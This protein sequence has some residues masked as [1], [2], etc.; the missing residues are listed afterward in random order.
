M[1]TI[2]KITSLLILSILFFPSCG[3]EDGGSN[4]T[5]G[6]ERPAD[7][8][9]FRS[10]LDI[11]PRM[12]T[13]AL[14]DNLWAAYST[15]NGSLYKAWKG[16]V[17]F[18]GAVYTTAHGP[19]PTSVGDA[20]ILGNSET[21]PWLIIENGQ[22]I[23]PTFQY[24]GHRFSN[25][26]AEMMYELSWN[27]KKAIVSEQPEYLDNGKGKAGFERTFTTSNV[28][29]GSQVALMANTSSVVSNSMVKTNGDFQ[30]INES[31]REYKKLSGVDLEGKLIL[32]SN[33]KTHFTSTFMARPLIPDPNKKNEEEE[34]ESPLGQRLIAKSDCKSCHNTFR[35]TIG[36]A[37]NDIAKKYSNT[38]Q[39]VAL[40]SAKIKNGGYGVW[41]SQ[42]MSAHPNESM[43]EIN[44]MVKYIMTLDAEEEAQM[45]A[46]SKES[47]PE[48]LDY[49]YGQKDIVENELLPG[50]IGTVYKDGT[51]LEKLADIKTDSKPIFVG[52]I[53][54]VHA[55]AGDLETLDH[56]FGIILEGYLNIPADANYTFRLLSDDGSRL[57]INGQVVI[58]NDGLHGASP[59]DG[60]IALAKGY[61]KLKVEYF[62]HGGGKMFSLEWR[63]GNEFQRVPTTA[64]LHNKNEE[65]QNFNVSGLSSDTKIPGDGS[66]LIGVHPSYDLTQARPG[67]FTP[68]VGGMDFLDDG[69]L[70][71]CTWDPNGSVYIVEG[72]QGGDPNK[73][74]Y[75][76]IGAGLAEPLGLKVVDNE[77]YILQ[78]QELTKLVDTDGDDMI[79]EYQT[80]C[81][82]WNVSANFHEFAFGLVY[83]EG[84][85]Y[86]TLAT[87]INPGGASTQP[88]I[89]DRGR[90]V[91]ISKADGSM[92]LI[93]SGL[94]TPNGIGLGV[95]NE[96]FV[97][98][99]QGDWLPASKIVHIK[100]GGWYG[101]RS[102]DFE[103]TEGMKENL[104]VVWLPQDEIGNSPSTPMYINDGIYTGQMIHG[105][106]TNGGVKRVFV[107]KI[108]GEYQ[109]CLFRFTQGLEA[110]VNRIIW[111]PDGA[112]YAG[113]VGSTGNWVHD[114]KLWYGLQRLKNNGKSTFEM[115]AV[116]A[117][118][119]GVE[120]EFTEPL[121]SGD[122]WNKSDYGVRQWFYKPTKEYGGPK[123]DEKALNIRSVNVSDDRKKVF[124]ELDGM[125]SNHMVYIKINT[126]FSSALGHEIWSTEAWYTMNQIPTGE[127]GFKTSAPPAT[128]VN[129][130][131]AFEKAA[132]WKSLF[133]GKS[134]AGWRNF[135]KQTV[136]SGWIVKD[137]AI[138]LNSKKGADGNWEAKDGGD[139]ITEGQYENYELSLEWKIGACGNSGVIF[140]VVE[141]A[142]YE[143]VWQT[144]P[145]M[146]VLDNTCHPDAKIRTHRAGDLYDMIECKYVTVKPAGQWNHARLVINKGKTEHW[147]NGRKVVEYEM[148]TDQW[149]D[150]IANSKFKDMPDFGKSKKGHISLQD[151]RDPVWYRNIK[152]REI[153]AIQ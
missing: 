13:F 40:L 11:K 150:M 42:V 109:G 131:S 31:P 135:N 75:K 65:P 148:F 114:G 103:G 8:W 85:F 78:K 128:A 120:I 32:K 2:F 9:V 104:P 30:I 153:K 22:E 44:E 36:P 28:P 41:G 18:D 90:V 101:S 127:P 14:N 143:F 94:R 91:K 81:N 141:D 139:I 152:I 55:D 60:A 137:D 82:S 66:A 51:P 5:N 83:K 53:P 70:V 100:E 86:G 73:M 119:N 33:D 21:M 24:K 43:T 25:G 35:K 29:E 54:Q 97:A 26:H 121:K 87:A 136:G 99:N 34:E 61:H 10:V 80:V 7:P 1:K 19:Q 47:V 57:N 124:L 147:L 27:G 79:D 112:L 17:E 93:A 105:E 106:V 116:R 118:S 126:P 92:K 12:V 45:S 95:D 46:M 88:Q 64:F 146:Q 98:D 4:K 111:G 68:R 20:Y 151:H 149:T 113:G 110:G 6:V 69:R 125:K 59:K 117:K 129:T 134:M 62:E 140:N 39:N 16:N 52:L 107:E 89:Q 123:L 72:A 84:Y 49:V 58:D 76:R 74:S 102:V 138:Y 145:E 115:L 144:G 67:L 3:T 108:N 142:K 48:N 96:I 63:T 37:Y 122:G 38:D 133:D 56:D 50:L 130:L 71:V 15:Q 23:K 77:I 132:G